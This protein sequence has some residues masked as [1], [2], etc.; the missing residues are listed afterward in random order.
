LILEA[1]SRHSRL[2]TPA[3]LG[4]VRHS[5]S[6]H[7]YFLEVTWGHTT[8]LERAITILIADRDRVTLSEIQEL[9][10]SNGF[11]VSQSQLQNA[12]SGLRLYN[13]LFKEGQ[14]YAFASGAFAEV[15]RE[16]QEVDILLNTLRDEM[17]E[18]TARGD[19]RLQ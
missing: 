15:V 14:Q 18:Q 7:E 3:D 8:A 10:S 5:S 12:I 16:S 4:Q 11:A 6:F 2:V 9:L 19:W 17:K 1:N 13:I